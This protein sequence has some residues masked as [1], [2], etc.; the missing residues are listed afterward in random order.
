MLSMIKYYLKNRKGDI[1]L[2]ELGKLILA[3]I[4]LVILVVIITLVIGGK[5]T[6]EGENVR[7]IFDF[8]K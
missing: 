4:L 6:E 8:F 2:D 5:F 1:E 3:A 7:G